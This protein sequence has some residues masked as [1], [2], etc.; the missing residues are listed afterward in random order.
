MKMREKRKDYIRQQFYLFSNCLE[1]LSRGISGDR[2]VIE[3]ELF[4][5]LRSVLTCITQG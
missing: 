1:G 2:E 4:V 5:I 3:M